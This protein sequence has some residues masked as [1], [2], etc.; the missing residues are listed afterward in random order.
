MSDN[1]AA[2]G[3]HLNDFESV[4]Y[5]IASLGSEYDPFVTSLTSVTILLDPLSLELCG[6]LLAH[7]MRID[8][9]LS[10]TEPTMPTTHFS[11]RA[12]MLHGRGYRVHGRNNYCGKD[13]LQ[14]AVAEAPTSNKIQQQHLLTL[15]ANYVGR[16]AILL[17]GVIIFL[18]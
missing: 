4:S 8:H 6:H 14:V 1:L 15:F 12:P 5:L 16:L 9:H 7:K 10:S 18:I 13:L 11:A 17:Q 3:Q 2:T